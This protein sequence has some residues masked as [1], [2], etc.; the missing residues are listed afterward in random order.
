MSMSGVCVSFRSV[1]SG[2]FLSSLCQC[3]K[4]SKSS[5]EYTSSADAGFVVNECHCL[6]HRVLHETVTISLYGYFVPHSVTE[7]WLFS[8]V[9]V[10]K[11][12][13]TSVH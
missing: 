8:S 9:D 4:R 11:Y 6:F 3:V 5:M 7:A 12:L 10:F 1:L 2:F 13:S